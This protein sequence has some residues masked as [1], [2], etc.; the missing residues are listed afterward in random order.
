MAGA[1]SGETGARLGLGRVTNGEA[2]GED[3]RRGLGGLT[4]DEGARD[5]EGRRVAVARNEKRVI[6]AALLLAVKEGMGKWQV[7]DDK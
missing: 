6:S 2:R 1:K 3:S 5:G 7:A 4:G